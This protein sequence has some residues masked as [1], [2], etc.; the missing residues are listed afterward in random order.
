MWSDYLDALGDFKARRGGVND[1]GTDA[2][3]APGFTGA[4]EY[5]IK[6][7]NAT[8]GDPSLF[9]VQDVIITIAP[10]FT[11]ERGD[12]GPGVT[13]REGKGSDSLTRGYG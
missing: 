12:I 1:K 7:G 9:T 11:L 13:F 8:V 4:S 10:G 2:A 3:R 6:I 5:D